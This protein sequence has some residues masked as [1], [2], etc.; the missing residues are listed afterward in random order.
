MTRRS[1]PMDYLEQA[2]RQPAQPQYSQNQ[3]QQHSQPQHTGMAGG[4]DSGYDDVSHQ[5]S[6]RLAD[7]A[8]QQHMNGNSGGQ[9]RKLVEGSSVFQ[10][11]EG[12][13]GFGNTITLART[14]GNVPPGYDKEFI[15]KGPKQVYIVA[16]GATTVDLSKVDESKMTTLIEISS[17]LIGT[18]LVPESA[19]Q[20]PARQ[21]GIQ[22]Q[23]ILRDSTMEGPNRY[24]E[25]QKRAQPQQQ[26]A[27]F[28]YKPGL[29][30]G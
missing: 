3:Y 1:S 19:I 29:I 17:P 25:Q 30:K 14:S 11:L 18:F 9:Q 23:Q 26:R 10:I 24:L 28:G 8:V 12:S 15:V 2:A 7:R 6:S 16:P 27:P 13:N 4:Y 5:I 22:S 21:T 20:R